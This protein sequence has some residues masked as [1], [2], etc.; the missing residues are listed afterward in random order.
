MHVNSHLHILC[1]HHTHLLYSIFLLGIP[2][3]TT[4][5]QESQEPVW[6]HPVL[7]A[8]PTHHSWIITTHV[9]LGDLDKQW[10]MFVQ[11]KARS[12]QLLNSLQW[13][14]LAPTYLL[15]ALQAKLANL[16]STYTSYKPLFLTATQLL[17]REPSFQS[18]SPLNKCMKRSILPFLGDALSWFTRT[19][20]TKDIRTS[21]GE[22]TNSL[23]QKPNNRIL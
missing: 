3:S 6:F 9:S 19:A 2:A 11:Q 13:K 20:M 18:K 10:K 7:K 5:Q 4:P 16:N 8:Y 1:T 15:S 21:R 17:K 22:W 14:P 23:N 12:Q